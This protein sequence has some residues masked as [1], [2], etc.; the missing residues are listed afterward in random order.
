[1]KKSQATTKKVQFD[2]IQDM[3]EF[4]GPHLEQLSDKYGADYVGDAMVKYGFCII[5]EVNPKRVK[6]LLKESKEFFGF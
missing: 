3:F 1:M 2:T 6:E 5:D 4:L